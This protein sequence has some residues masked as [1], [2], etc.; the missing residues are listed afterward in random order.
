MNLPTHV[1][2]VYFDILLKLLWLYLQIQPFIL[3]HVKPMITAN[4][5][6][7]ISSLQD[8]TN[9]P[10]LS[11]LDSQI[12]HQYLKFDS[13]LLRLAKEIVS[14]EIDMTCA[15]LKIIQM[16]IIQ[17][18]IKHQNTTVQGNLLYFKYYD[19]RFLQITKMAH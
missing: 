18:T 6:N 19:T 16:Y 1:K 4:L 5:C 11:Y 15:L 9:K 10:E 3:P 14:D 2:I 17:N 8:N 13:I 7:S 12:S